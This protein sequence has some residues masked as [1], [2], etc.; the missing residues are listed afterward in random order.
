MRLACY[1]L[2]YGCE[3]LAWSIRSVQDAVDEIHVFYSRKPSYGFADP[4]ATNPDTEEML[5]AEAHRFLHK[6][7]IW[8]EVHE[9]SEGAHRDHMI[10]VARER[11]AELY[12]VVDSDE[13]WDTDSAK[14]TLDAVSRAN[15]AGRWLARFAN[16]W[17]SFKYQVHDGFTPV[18]VVDMRHPITV[19]AYLSAE[20][21]PLPVYHFGYAQTLRTMEYKLTTHG[22]KAEFRPGWYQDKFVAWTPETTDIHP[23]VNNLWVT[24]TPT[25]PVTLGHVRRI[26]HDHP[27][28]DVDVIR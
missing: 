7:L 26:L 12:L 28:L 3:Y 4:N 17:R 9:G 10:R 5:R 1:A 24:A 2:H 21:Q 20:Q 23:T 27:Y 6:P 22:H 19:D 14:A 8:H 13:I 11:G 18:R 15:S 16:F 25:E